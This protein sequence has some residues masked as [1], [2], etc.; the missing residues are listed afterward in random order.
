MGPCSRPGAYEPLTL[1]P[2]GRAPLPSH[3]SSLDTL[4]C[5]CPSDPGASP[6]LSVMCPP[7]GCRD[8]Q[9]RVK[10][11]PGLMCCRWWLPSPAPKP[12]KGR[13]AGFD[14]QTRVQI[15]YGITGGLNLGLSL[16]PHPQR[17]ARCSSTF[18]HKVPYAGGEGRG[19]RESR[20]AA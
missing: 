6:S 8:S 11:S 5:T 2:L 4:L 1:H 10:G 19:T 18:S 13:E 9:R 17:P 16:A 7:S 14:L 20:S 3:W 15:R 12:G